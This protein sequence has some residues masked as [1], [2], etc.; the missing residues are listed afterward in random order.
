MKKSHFLL[1]LCFAMS[2]LFAQQQISNTSISYKIEK[3]NLTRSSTIELIKYSFTDSIFRT[4]KFLP[5]SNVHMTSVKYCNGDSGTVFLNNGSK[6]YNYT[7]IREH[8]LE[9]KG[10]SDFDINYEYLNDTITINSIFCKKALLHTKVGN[11]RITLSV[12]YNAEYKLKTGCFHNLFKDLNC[13]PINF[14]YKKVINGIITDSETEVTLTNLPSLTTPNIAAID[15]LQKYVRIS[16]SDKQQVALEMRGNGVEKYIEKGEPD[17]FKVTNSDND[18]SFTFRKSPNPFQV[19]QRFTNFDGNTID[20]KE[21]TLNTIRGKVAVINF[22]F[23]NCAPCV[24]EIPVLNKVQE[25]YQKRHVSFIGITHSKN[26]EVQSFLR[27]REFNFEHIVDA[28]NLIENW[29]I[30]SFPLTLIIDQKGTIVFSKDGG[31]S[32]EKEV[33]DIIDKLLLVKETPIQQK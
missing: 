23:T 13:I 32:N 7:E 22:W 25:L 16:A 29:K 19:G 28:Q 6:Y 5:K 11:E 15:S 17:A 9:I 18:A 20:E 8:F 30:I 2:K 33:T 24:T 31:I 21:I 4:E 26:D 27:N 10:Y 3:K 14:F 12:W 1:V